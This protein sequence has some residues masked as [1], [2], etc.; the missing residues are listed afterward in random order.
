VLAVENITKKFPGVTALDDVSMDFHP[1]KVNAILGENG[2]GKSTLMKV[3]SGVYCDY[4]GTILHNGK[5]VVFSGIRDAQ[6]CGIAI[7]HQELNLILHLSIREN[8]FLGR[9]IVN[10]WGFLDKK[11]M[12]IK[13]A[14]LLKKLKLEVDPD[15]L[16]ADLKVGQ[17]QVVEI[18]K[19]LLTDSQVIIMDEPTSA[20]SD[21][22]VEV[23]FDIINEL[24]KENKTIVYIS[25]KL[26]ELFRIADRYIVMRDGRSIESGDMKGMTHEHLIQKMV[27]RELQIFRKQGDELPQREEL[28]RVHNLSLKHPEKKG[29]KLLKNISFSLQKS[30]VVGLFGLMGAGRT[31]LM[32]ALFGIHPKLTSGELYVIGKLITLRSPVD[33]IKAGIALVPEDRKNDGLVLSLDVRSNIS[34]T[35]LKDMEQGFLLNKSKETALSR[36]YINELKIKTSSDKQIVRNLSGGNQQKIVIAKWL[37]KKPKILLLDEPT[38]G[39]DINAKNEIYKLILQLAKAGLG[40]IMVSS[41]LPEILA[42]SDRVLVLSEGS[43]TAEIP[44]RDATENSILKAAIPKTI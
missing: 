37:A 17:Q 3:L 4:E 7:I 28:L 15:T 12:R 24:R 35:T 16:V 36:Q 41:E 40:I 22:E 5:P 25:H 23:L 14:S 39:I 27:G 11:S 8:V 26:D 18:S 19:A 29:E 9:E 42:V 21:K 13:T 38:R 31:E 33:A 2:A 1:G 30:E 44:I 34:L 43:L 32:E 10:P 20:I 6:A